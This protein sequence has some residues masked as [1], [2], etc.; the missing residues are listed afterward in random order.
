MEAYSMMNR[1]ELA[2]ARKQA[3]L[4]GDDQAEQAKIEKVFKALDR[5]ARVMSHSI[6]KSIVI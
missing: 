1:Y 2:A 4:N 3:W 6:S 5:K